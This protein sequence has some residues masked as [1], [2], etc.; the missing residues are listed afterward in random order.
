[1]IRRVRFTVLTFLSLADA[2]EAREARR[3]RL[4]HD[5]TNP[6]RGGRVVDECGQHPRAVHA[7]AGSMVGS[8]LRPQGVLLRS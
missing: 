3:A 4:R 6:G 7:G 8:R 2:S 5:A 1:M